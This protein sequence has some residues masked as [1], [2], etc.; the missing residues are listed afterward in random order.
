MKR[1][2]MSNNGTQKETRCFHL[3]YRPP[4][5]GEKS[6]WVKDGEVGL[7][8]GAKVGP[9]YLVRSEKGRA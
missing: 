9:R 3:H 1:L 2:R 7:E 4:V 8:V 6:I 5:K